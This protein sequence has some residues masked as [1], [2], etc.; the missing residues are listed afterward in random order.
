MPPAQPP[1]AAEPAPRA[2]TVDEADALAASV[3]RA[4]RRLR[5]LEELAE[6]GMDSTRA[7]RRRVLAAEA[8]AD[9]A[10]AAGPPPPE[11]PDPTH[12]FARLSRA[13]H[14]TLDLE[15]RT[16]EA[17]RALQTGEA[18]AREGAP[19]RRRRRADDAR[20]DERAAKARWVRGQV[21]V[22]IREQSESETEE[23]ERGDALV[24]RLTR[25][26]AYGDLDDRP[27]RRAVE[28]LCREL[29][30]APDWSRWTDEGWAARGEAAHR[31][32]LWSPFNRVSRRPIL[33]TPFHN[34]PPPRRVARLE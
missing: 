2:E 21:A 26:H 6:I 20:A 15:A 25:D 16:D 31:R 3:R 18:V 34:D 8:A 12:A 1:P 22:I 11:P 14:L 33:E 5:Q 7:L 10:P 9:A 13:V 23:T 29:D 4:E 32:L 24:E 28:D 17:L 30:L 19:E 27:L